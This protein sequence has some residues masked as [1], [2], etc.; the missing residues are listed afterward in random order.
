MLDADSVRV[1]CVPIHRRQMPNM[2]QPWMTS[3]R[4]QGANL[5]EAAQVVTEPSPGLA[6]R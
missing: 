3:L 1:Q 2:K 6:V 4:E 5:M